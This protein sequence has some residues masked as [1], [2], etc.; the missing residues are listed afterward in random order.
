MKPAFLPDGTFTDFFTGFLPNIHS[1]LPSQIFFYINASF[2]YQKKAQYSN[3]YSTIFKLIC[4]Y[5]VLCDFAQTGVFRCSISQS[6]FPKTAQ[7]PFSLPSYA[8]QHK[9]QMDIGNHSLNPSTYSNLFH[10]NCRNSIC[11]I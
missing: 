10:Y 6:P 2:Y 4:P 3:I 7:M 8:F 11:L 9:I 1:P 5:F